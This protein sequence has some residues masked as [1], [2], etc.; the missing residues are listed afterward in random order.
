MTTNQSGLSP[1]TDTGTGA[2]AGPPSEVTYS[3]EH[4]TE[5]TGAVEGPPKEVTVESPPEHLSKPTGAADG[6]PASV[7]YSQDQSKAMADTKQVSASEVE[8]KAVS[9]PEREPAKG[10]R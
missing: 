3:Q 4:D 10:R 8:D 2:Y 7:T 9:R 1:Y 5:P 6:P